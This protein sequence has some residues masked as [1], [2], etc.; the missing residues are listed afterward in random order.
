MALADFAPPRRLMAGGGPSLPDLRVLRALTTPL[1]GQF[2]PAFTAIMDEVMG[3]ARRVLQTANRRC[4]PISGLASAGVEALRNTLPEDARF[5]VVEHVDERGTLAPLR[6]LAADAHANGAWL[7]VDATRTL[8]GL[9]VRTDDW[10]LD[11]VVAGVDHCLGAPSGMTLVTYNAEIERHLRARTDPPRTSYLD[12]LQLEAY[13]S[14][15]RLNHHTAPTSLVYGLREALRLVLEEGLEERWARHR[16]IGQ[17]LHDGLRAL[18]LAPSGEPPF[19]HL[20]VMDSD[21]LRRRL[22]DEYGLYVRAGDD[23]A[24][25]LGLLGADAQPEV[26][27]SVLAVLGRVL[28]A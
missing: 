27:E 16:R 6:E 18:G 5:D 22:L 25:R 21:R 2:D 23:G 20:A 24:L 7:I 19:A 26:V 8:G 3:L 1:V 13:W 17:T 28:V 11:A 15:E 9:D 10:G 14:P 12:L 4:F